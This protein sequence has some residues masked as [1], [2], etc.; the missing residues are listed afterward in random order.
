MADGAAKIAESSNK[1]DVAFETA[2]QNSTVVK[3]DFFGAEASAAKI[4]EDFAS[5]QKQ[6]RNAIAE[7][8]NPIQ[9]S[10][11]RFSLNQEPSFSTLSLQMTQKR[12]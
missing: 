2:K 9:I 8:A 7:F 3:Q 4:A 6:A 11:G 5:L 1:F 12:R 10:Q